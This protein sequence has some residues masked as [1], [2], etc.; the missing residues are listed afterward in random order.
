MHTDHPMTIRRDGG[1]WIGWVDDVPGV[2]CQERTYDEL[3]ESLRI[4]LREALD[5]EEAARTGGGDP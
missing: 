2:N 4:T 3:V 5:L 1:W